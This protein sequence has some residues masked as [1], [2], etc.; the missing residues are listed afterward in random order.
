MM[1][2]GRRSGRR[3]GRRGPIGVLVAMETGA[4]VQ[5]HD[6]YSSVLDP[7]WSAKLGIACER[8]LSAS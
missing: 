3:G 2:T 5:E 6:D 7:P 4:R 1:A 8:F